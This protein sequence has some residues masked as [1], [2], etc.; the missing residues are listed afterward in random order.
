MFE[1]PIIIFLTIACSFHLCSCA[2]KK[3]RN[4]PVIHADSSKSVIGNIGAI[5]LPSHGSG[6]IV[7]YDKDQLP[8]VIKDYYSQ[9]WDGF[10]IANPNEDWDAGCS[11]G[12][13]IV[14]SVDKNGQKHTRVIHFRPDKQLVSITT[15]TVSGTYLVVYDC[16]GIAKMSISDY[17]KVLKDGSLEVASIPR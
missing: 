17:F 7:L 13:G 11:G 8:Q 16:G 1:K 15:D 3:G 9:K 2:N 5:N 10:N 12:M 6:N 4:S 14:D